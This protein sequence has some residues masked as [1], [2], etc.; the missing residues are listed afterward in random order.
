MHLAFSLK[1]LNLLSA[2]FLLYVSLVLEN[3]SS[4][5]RCLRIRISC[6]FNSVELA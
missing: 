2:R 3:D 6:T 5:L 1:F 4:I